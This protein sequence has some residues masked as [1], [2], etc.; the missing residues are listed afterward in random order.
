MNWEYVIVSPYNDSA[1]GMRTEYKLTTLM[2]NSE[3]PVLFFDN[4]AV[5]LRATRLLEKPWRSSSQIMGLATYLDILN[6]VMVPYCPWHVL[7]C[8]FED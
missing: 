3:S 5:K 2:E 6:S 7:A 1:D 4:I 8:N